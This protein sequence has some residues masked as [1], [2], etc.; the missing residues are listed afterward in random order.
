MILEQFQD[1]MVLVLLFA[2]VLGFVFAFLEEDPEERVTAFIEPWVIII[3]LA[4]NAFISVMQEISAESSVEAL[5][6]FQAETA[7]VTRDGKLVQINSDDVVCGDLIEVGEGQPIPCDIRI[8]HIRS[9][10][11]KADEAALTGESEPSTKDEKTLPKPTGPIMNQDKCNI[12]FGGTPVVRGRFQ[13]IAIAVGPQSEIGK[14]HKSVSETDEQQTPLQ[15]QLDQFGDVISKGILVICIITWL[16]NINK[17]KEAGHGSFLKGA[18]SFFKI[19]VSLAVA[20]IPEGLPAVVTT[21]L[22]LGVNRMAKEKAIV[23]KLPAVE[24]L[25]CTS[26]I[27]SDKTGTL[28]TNNMTVRAALTVSEGNVN[29]FEVEGSSYSPQGHIKS[30]GT[31]V[32]NLTE[33]FALQESAK[34]GTLCNDA[35]ILYDAESKTFARSGEPTEAAFKVFAEKVGLPDATQDAEM[36]KKKPFDRAHIV[37]DYYKETFPKK[38]THEFTRDRK[39]M[40][41]VVGEHTLLVK[42]A[43]EVILSHCNR[44]IDDKTGQVLD[45]NDDVRSKLDA[46]RHEW[47]TGS[48][49]FRCMG[50][51]YKDAPGYENWNIADFAELAKNE[52]DLVWA[53][54]VGIIDPPRDSVTPSIKECHSAGIRVI[55]CT[56]DNPDT[57]TAIAKHIC[58]L[59]EN[60]DTKGKVFTGVQWESMTQSEKEEAAKH[61]VVLARVEPRHKMELVTILQNQGHVVAMT[62]DGVNDSPALKKAD[63]GVAMGSGTKV[64]QEAAKMILSDDSFTTIVK[65]VAEGRAIYN[66]TTAFIRYLITCNIGEVVSCFVSS[67]IGGPNLLRSTQLLFVNLVT[68]GL[69]ATALGVNPPEKGVMNLPPR[70]KNESIVTPITLARYLVGGFYLGFATIAAAY[71]WY[72][73]DPQGPGLTFKQII[74][75]QQAP[76]ELHHV[77]EDD[78]PSTMAMSVLV[79]VE[80]F[81]AMTAISERQSFFVMGPWENPYLM[82]AI[83]GSLFVHLLT[84]EVPIMRRIFS[85]VSLDLDHYVVLLILGVPALI[86]EEIFKA[87]IR[88]HTKHVEVEY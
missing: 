19:A 66:N 79:I 9:T 6:Q 30:G 15:V 75:W 42:G 56:G 24:T 84:L 35:S 68:D 5:K 80:M 21:T 82:A 4:L 69:P 46:T 22:S 18:L 45:L 74:T 72:M 17:F 87:Y 81:S 11:L 43:Y 86:I 53:G 31:Q 1:K 23:T 14:I 85:V 38:R 47:S 44:Y 62:G 60:E 29:V 37:S 63:I 70:P 83:V 51:A 25:G 77:F 20:A 65:A 2:V 8:I 26:V 73:Y 64:A 33:H 54:A 13:G 39:S 41:V 12:C 50:V 49:C 48:S 58:M 59:H 16:A 7:N 67:I 78:T 10:I 57:A 27:C 32:S 88:A 61:A 52:L 36:K 71:Y 28:T 76:P 40:S 34:I 55:M 3:I